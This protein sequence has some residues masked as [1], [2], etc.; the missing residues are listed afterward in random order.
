MML[1]PALIS[2]LLYE[3]FRGY[4]LSM[5]KR[6]M[7]LL[8]FAFLINM[9]GYVAFWLRGWEYIS[10]SLGSESTVTSV[11]FIVYY[12]V[13]SLVVAVVFPFILSLIRIGKKYRTEEQP[14]RENENDK[15]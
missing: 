9:T 15:I 4:L 2:V 6:L 10:W 7:L 5:Q 8:V 12:M 11:S 3:R 1:I 14:Q 13:I